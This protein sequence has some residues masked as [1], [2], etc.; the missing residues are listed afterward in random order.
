MPEDLVL[1]N[2]NY[3]PEMQGFP[4]PFGNM[5]IKPSSRTGPGYHDLDYHMG[6]DYPRAYV[7]WST[8]RN[9]VELLRPFGIREMARTGPVAMLRGPQN[10]YHSHHSL[11]NTEEISQ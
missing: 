3:R 2:A 1:G 4:V 7:R 8:R 6:Q 5:D 11:Q 9:F 10:G